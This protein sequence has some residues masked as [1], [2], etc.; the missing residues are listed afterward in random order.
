MNKKI[1]KEEEIDWE[2]IERMENLNDHI[3]KMWDDVMVPYLE[4]FNNNLILDKLDPYDPTPFIKLF[5]EE[6]FV[7]KDLE[8]F[9]SPKS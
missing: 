3:L 8:K 4:D 9:K 1:K 5:C 2:H 6:N 7:Y